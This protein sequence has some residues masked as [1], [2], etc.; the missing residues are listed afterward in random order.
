[1]SRGPGRVERALR[2]A[3]RA[4]P[5]DCFTTDELCQIA[6]GAGALSVK[7]ERV[8]VLRAANKIFAT[9]LEIGVLRGEARGGELVWF[10]MTSLRSYAMAQAMRTCD[11]KEAVASLKRGRFDKDIVEGGLWH[12][13]VESWRQEIEARRA[14]DTERLEQVLAEREAKNALLRKLLG[15]YDRQ[16]A[17]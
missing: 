7:S 14:G 8:A 9:E 13:T 16:L 6:Y 17:R 4:R 12:G 5:D 11:R 10:T 2:D 1:M 3:F 15:S